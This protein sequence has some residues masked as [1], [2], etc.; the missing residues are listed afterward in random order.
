M[1]LDY[2]AKFL[3]GVSVMSKEKA[4][5]FPVKPYVSLPVWKIKGKKNKKFAK[6]FNLQFRDKIDWSYDKKKN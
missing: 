4:L 5:I 3:Y 6:K 1:N 2:K